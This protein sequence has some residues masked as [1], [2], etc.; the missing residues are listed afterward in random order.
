M[1]TTVEIL[2]NIFETIKA[3]VRILVESIGYVILYVFFM[4]GILLLGYMGLSFVL[5][6]NHIIDVIK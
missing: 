2:N 3:V 4:L 1:K 6:A 5:A